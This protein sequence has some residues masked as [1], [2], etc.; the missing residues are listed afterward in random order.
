MH[1]KT[2][3]TTTHTDH[4]HVEDVREQAIVLTRVLALDP[5]RETILALARSLDAEPGDFKR[6][7]AVERA[8]RDLTCVGLV[9][10]ISGRVHPTAA[11][12]RFLEIVESGV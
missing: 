4:D 2:N 3:G 11:A 8:V 9:E 7:G 5:E 1:S 12:R 6:P 10:I